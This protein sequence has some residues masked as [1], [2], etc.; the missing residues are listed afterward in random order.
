MEEP[1]FAKLRE[2]AE[3][4]ELMASRAASPV[5][6]RPC[7]GS[8]LRLPACSGKREPAGRLVILRFENLT[9]DP[10]CDWIEPWRRAPARRSA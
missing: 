1:E 5:K 6:T 3:F 8:C 10:A 4:K 9:G 7:R 2:T